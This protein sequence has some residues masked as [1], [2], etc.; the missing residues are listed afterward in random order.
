MLPG[1]RESWRSSVGFLLATVGA[2]VGLGNLWRFSY[3]ASSGG[4]AAFVI[5]DLGFVVLVGLPVLT[6]E[7]VIGRGTRLSPIRALP[8]LGGRG[9]AL[10]GAAF[11]VV[12]T[13]VLSV[14]S[15][16]MGWTLRLLLDTVRGAV[17][18]D[19]VVHFG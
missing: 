16:I 17:P 1:P 13:L 6:A 4:G 19:T 12:G 18:E 3:T 9:W 5:L 10:L 7:L 8:R 2:A 11:V 14:Y 15:N